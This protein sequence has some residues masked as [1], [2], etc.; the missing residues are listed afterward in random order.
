MDQNATNRRFPEIN[1]LISWI[2]SHGNPVVDNGDGTLTVTS[3]AVRDGV[4]SL[5]KDTISATLAAAR[6]LLGY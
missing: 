2:E 6:D 5:E 3:E 4:V 1:S